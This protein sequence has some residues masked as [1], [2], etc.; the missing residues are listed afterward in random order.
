MIRN[1]I[2]SIRALQ[3]VQARII[4]IGS[5]AIGLYLAKILVEQGNDVLVIESGGK[6]LGG[7]STNSFESIGRKSTGIKIGRSRSLGGT[8][9]LWGGQLVEFR[10]FDIDGR[11]WISGSKWPISYDELSPYYTKSYERLGIPIEYQSDENVLKYVS[12]QETIIKGD[13]EL[14]LTRWM[15]IPSLSRLYSKDIESNQNLQVLLNHTVVGFTG[16]TANVTNVKVRRPDGVIELIPG[17]RFVVTAGAIETS[18]LLLMSAQDKS[19][20]CPWKNNYNVGKVFQDHLGGR[21]AVVHPYNKKQFFKTFSTIRWKGYKFQPKLRQSTKYLISNNK[22]GIHA[23][24]LF[25][26]SVSENL[27]FLKQFLK[28]ALYSRRITGLK[29]FIL[30]TITCAKYLL[31][32]MITYIKD[33][34]IFV[35]SNSKICIQIQA[36]LFPVSESKITIDVNKKDENSMPKVILDWKI[37]GREINTIKDFLLQCNN[38]LQKNNFGTL[39]IDPKIIN[40]DASYLDSLSDTNHP[41]GGAIMGIDSTDGVVDNN[42]KIFG[43]DNLFVAGS[44]VFRT[45]SSA[46]VTFTA[47]ALAMRLAYHLNNKKL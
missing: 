27:I 47:M 21:A 22:L 16:D 13:I 12:K 42:L 18:R 24:L 10:S 40:L 25:E 31:P 29:D 41:S 1:T 35:P 15:N 17:N 7:F 32:L 45:S 39:E 30:N 43:T 19:W 9:N 34:R 8:S 2:N 14:C 46:N 23:M 3:G 36:E 26:S 44:S 4:I 11:D 38:T 28:A 5:G 20:N 6:N 37:D 33:H